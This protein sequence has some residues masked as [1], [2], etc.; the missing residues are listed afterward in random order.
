VH[1]SAHHADGLPD[2]LSDPDRIA[3]FDEAFR[4][5]SHVLMERDDDTGRLV[6]LDDGQ[7]SRSRFSSGALL[8]MNP[9]WKLAKQVH[10]VRSFL[11]W[12]CDPMLGLS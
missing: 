7:P 3:F 12:I 8:G 1:G 11:C 2:L 5:G 9:A 10:G 4:G 6:R